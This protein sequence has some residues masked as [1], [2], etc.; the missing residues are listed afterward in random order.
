[1]HWKEHNAS[2]S[3]IW[4]PRNQTPYPEEMHVDPFD[5]HVRDETGRLC[6]PSHFSEFLSTTTTTCL[7]PPPH[8]K[9]AAS[10]A[11][12][13]LNLKTSLKLLSKLQRIQSTLCVQNAPIAARNTQRSCMWIQM[14]SFL[15]Q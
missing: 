4:A 3:A 5:G 11:Q 13:I 6:L 2:C 12:S 14:L 9:W 1:M 10:N 15:C 8:K 7:I